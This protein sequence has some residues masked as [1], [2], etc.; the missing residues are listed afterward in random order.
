MKT[1]AKILSTAAVSALVG[2][3]IGTTLELIFSVGMGHSYSPGIPA[4][5]AEFSNPLV[6]IL[7]TRALYMVLGIIC[8]LARVVYDIERLSLFAASLIHL[9]ICALAFLV[10]GTYLKW[11]IGLGALLSFF[12]IYVAIYIILWIYNL[13]KIKQLNKNL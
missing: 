3:A 1:N 11:G 4:F 6:A 9:T 5:L 12:I 8:G 13:I 2:L 10:I 7:I